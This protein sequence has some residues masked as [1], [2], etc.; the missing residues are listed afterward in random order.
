ML[1]ASGAGYS[2]WRDLAV[3]RWRE[4]ATRDDHGSFVFMRDVQTGQ[5][6]SPGRIDEQA[7]ARSRPSS[8]VKTMQ[9]SRDGTDR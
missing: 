5:T 1:T 3:T 6:W 4:D 9:S 8:S 7:A 2:R